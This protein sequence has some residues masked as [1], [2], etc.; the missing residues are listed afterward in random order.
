MILPELLPFFE[1]LT[2][3]PQVSNIPTALA[4]SSIHNQAMLYVFWFGHSMYI[5][6]KFNARKTRADNQKLDMPFRLTA[7]DTIGVYILLNC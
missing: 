2:L 7:P 6:S 4:C 1:T 3:Q 5:G